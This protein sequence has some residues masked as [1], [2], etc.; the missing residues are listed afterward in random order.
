ML[1]DI[2]LGKITTWNDP[3]IAKLNP[4]VK[5][6]ST[7]ITPVYRTDGSGD[8]YAFTNYL[9]Q[10]SPE[11]KSKVGTSTQ[12]HFPTGLGGK[13]NSG[14]GGVLPSTNGAIA[15]VAIA[16]VLSNKFDYA[17]IQNAAGKFPAPGITSISAAAATV[18]TIP[19][20]QRDLDRRPA[21][22]GIGRVP[23]LDVH[24]RDRPEN[25]LRRRR[26]SSRSSPGR[27]RPGQDRAEAR[28][29]AAAVKGRL[30]ARRYKRL[31]EVESGGNRAARVHDVDRHRR[32]RLREQPRPAPFAPG[33]SSPIAI[34]D[35]LLRLLT[36]LAALAGVG[37]LIWIAYT[38]F[39]E[40]SPAISQF[41]LGVR[42]PRRL[43]PVNRPVRRGGL[44]LRHGR[45]LADGAHA[46]RRRC[47]SPSRCS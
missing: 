8:T 19:S 26:R 37:V 25:E 44:H 45:E 24:V 3:P 31:D 9:S 12:V 35:P 43:E 7:K 5:L 4:G 33:A 16:Y 29:R 20:R 22:V 10:V 39:D 14:V 23:D 40:A 17:L 41:G 28:L 32:V 47:R 15:Y 2:Y 13:G 46:R 30:G 21:G 1:A 11:C 38:V 34:G 18:K 42:R 36:G 6:P 27:S